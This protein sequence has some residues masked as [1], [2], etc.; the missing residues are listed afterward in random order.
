MAILDA[1]IK[2]IIIAALVIII[3]LLLFSFYNNEF[4]LDK[5]KGAAIEKGYADLTHIDFKKDKIIALGGEWEFYWKELLEPKDF[6]Q[7]ELEKNFINIPGEINNTKKDS[8][9]FTENGYGTMRINIKIKDIDK[10]YGIKFNYFA[11]ANK[12]W[13]NGEEVAASGKVASED[14][15]FKAQYIP[16]EIFFKG[17][18]ETVAIVV[19]LANFPHRRI[20]LKQVDFGNYDEIIKYTNNKL[21]KE[22]FIIG[23]LIL[24]AIYYAILFFIQR[25]EAACLYLAIISFIVAAREAIVSERL[26]MRIFPS[27]PPEIMMK[28]GYLPVFILFPL[29]IF[30]VKEIFKTSKLDMIVKVC[31][32][33]LIISFGVILLFS[34][35]VYDWIFQYFQWMILLGA[36]YSIYILMVNGL[37]KKT[38]G[39]YTMALGGVFVLVAAV[40]DTLRELAII[41][42]PELLA[43]AIVVFIVLQA[44]FLAWKFNDSFEEVARLAEQNEAMYEEIQELNK[45]LE[46]KVKDRTKE[47]EYVNMRLEKMSKIDSLTTLFNRRFFDER[48]QLEWEDSLQE[49]KPIAIIMIDVD[50]FKGFNDNYGHLKGD[51]CLKKIARAIKKTVA[52]KNAITT[53]YGG[54]EFVVLLWNSEVKEACLVAEEIRKN[55]M[56]LKIPH[57]LSHINEY[58]T[59]S[60]GVNSITV[61]KAS[62]KEDFI[63]GADK[64]LY[65][66]K[67]K[68]RNTVVVC[69]KGK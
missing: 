62:K 33:L 69:P 36:V 48:L 4:T 50:F 19:Q 58:V 55:V 52:Y 3:T 20:V 23:C 18:T 8:K 26:L 29:V 15:L 53:R 16:Q 61:T 68:G 47:L 1:K 54:E 41:N 43:I 60:A 30:Y 39:T 40:N 28:I 64:A 42:T 66:A 25:R 14:K 17:T 10:I 7:K 31:K 5:I 45:D 22:S 11:S 2:K 44:V 38:R 35:K 6:K 63:N 65:L 13:I 59:I 46:I 12:I 67:E 24:V 56:N 37:F 32:Y 49:Q 34:V 27:F 9:L 21:I 51:E 57:K